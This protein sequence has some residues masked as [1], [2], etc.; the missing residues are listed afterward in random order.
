MSKEQYLT[1][2]MLDLL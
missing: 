1:C 2:S